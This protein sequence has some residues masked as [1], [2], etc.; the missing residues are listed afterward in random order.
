MHR[1]TTRYLT[2]LLLPVLDD[3]GVEGWL[4]RPRGQYGDL[5]PLEL[6]ESGDDDLVVALALELVRTA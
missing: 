1:D 4:H 5:T 3:V 2:Q 6:L